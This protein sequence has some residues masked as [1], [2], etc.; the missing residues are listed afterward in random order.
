MA[1]EKLYRNTLKSVQFSS[2]PARFQTMTLS[3]NKGLER[4]EKDALVYRCSRSWVFF[5]VT[6]QRKKKRLLVV[7]G[8]SRLREVVAHG[9]SPGQLR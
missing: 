9:G 4:D 8:G 7:W 1:S 6:L 2:Q 5:A 3:Y